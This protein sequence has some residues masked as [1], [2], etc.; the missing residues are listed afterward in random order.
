MQTTTPLAETTTPLAETRERRTPLGARGKVEI[1][2]TLL[3]IVGKQ[4]TPA[5]DVAAFQSF[6]D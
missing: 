4:A 5:L 6:A 2:Q 1:H 3:R